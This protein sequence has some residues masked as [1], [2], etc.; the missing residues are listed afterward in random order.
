VTVN[1]RLRSVTFPGRH[2]HRAGF[3]DVCEIR[4]KI[5]ELTISN[6]GPVR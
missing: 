3:V 5:P 2:E 4:A 1:G 6:T